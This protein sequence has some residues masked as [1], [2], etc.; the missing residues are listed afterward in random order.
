MR[1]FIYIISCFLLTLNVQAQ[2]EVDALRYSYTTGGGTARYMGLGGAFGALGADLSTASSNPAGLARY[3]KSEF[4]F[5]PG[6]QLGASNSSFNNSTSY[7]GKNNLNITNIGFVSST[8]NDKP[9][10]SAWK[11]VQ[12]AFTYNKLHNYHLKSTITGESQSSITQAIANL[13]NGNTID[14]LYNFHPFD[15]GLFYDGYLIDPDP[16]DSLSYFSYIETDVSFNKNIERSGQLGETAISMSG[17]YDDILYVGGT[18]G[19]QKINYYEKS[20]Y[21][22]NIIDQSQ[23]LITD[24]SHTEELN[25]LGRG[26]NI[27]G[28]VI[29]LPV[30]W[31]RVG[32]AFHSP[33]AFN[34]TEEY[35]TTLSSSDTTTNPPINVESPYNSFTYKIRL[36]SKT[37]LSAAAVIKKRG[38]ISV[39]VELSNPREALLKDQNNGKDL[40]QIENEAIREV[41]QNVNVFRLG[42]EWKL[43][44]NFVARGGIS[45]HSSPI[46]KDFIDYNASRQSVSLGLGYR[47]KNFFMDVAFVSTTWTENYYLYD[48]NLIDATK[49]DYYQNQ[50]LTTVGFRF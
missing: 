8:I 1:I 19:I 15:L 9:D 5:T 33:T 29:Y 21:T 27:K 28:G 32:V 47:Q 42:T 20:T 44:K 48:P 30:D 39:D 25:V 23:S 10:I 3:S 26:I 40:F 2:N 7:N 11:S 34:I 24:L 41:H 37:I 45:L 14:D 17:N 6:Y 49:I 31:L 22:E 13:A 50:L 12:F 43:S 38:L 35:Q 36:P 4:V 18:I 46:K 16:T